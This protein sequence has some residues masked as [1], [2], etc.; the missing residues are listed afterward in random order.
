MDFN[1]DIRY[2]AVS[3]S[4]GQILWNS[5]RTGLKNLVP[6][7][8]TKQTLM[9][10]LNAWKEN[11]NVKNYIGSGRYSIS[12]YEKIKRITIPLDNGKLLFCTLSNTPLSKA[13]TGRKKSY[14]H[15]VDM[16]K[17]LS[18]VDFIKSQK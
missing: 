2:A 14:G 18:I 12:S 9:R 4:N 8:E 3:D 1:E 16:G 10:A 13:T 7:E 6:I 17:I 15:L 5:Q 11:A